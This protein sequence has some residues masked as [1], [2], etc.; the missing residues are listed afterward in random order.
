V[1]PDLFLTRT[2]REHPR[3]G[4]ITRVLA[5]ALD[6]VEPGSVVSRLISF[7]RETL[8]IAGKPITVEGKIFT[9]GFGKAAVAMTRS[10]ADILGQRLHGGLIVTKH[11]TENTISSLDIIEGGHPIPDDRSLAAGKRIE[12]FVSSLGKDDLLICL[13]SGGGSALVADPVKGVSL[14]DLQSLTSSLLECG[15]RIDEI[16]ILRRQ[17]DRLKGGGLAQMASPARVVSLILS[18]VVGNPLEVIASGPTFPDPTTAADAL[19][20]LDRY[21]LSK[22]MPKGILKVLRHG[23]KDERPSSYDHVQNIIVGS[24]L[25]AAQAA[26]RQAQEEGFHPYL[27]RTDLQGEARDVATDLSIQLRWAWKMGDPVPRPACIVAGGE[28]TV[29]VLG[30]GRGGR[31]TELALAA[32]SELADFPDVMLV[33]FA[34]DGEDGATDAAGAVVT[35]NTWRSGIE[36]D[37]NSS[38]FLNR[39][40]SYNYFN[41]LEDLLKPGL[42]GTNVNDLTFLFTF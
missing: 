11:M 32:V 2:L 18:D 19:E 20:V 13:I 33:T 16:N 1:N 15:A 22:K 8:K 7:D 21:G 25:M 26:L 24:N 28:T 36:L 17:L 6:A 23:Q 4:S 14:E 41:A 37:M 40:D 30:G 9:L 39:N 5:A 29:T 34:T 38:E 31:N 35:G 3:G 42:T 10:L 27:L 12:E